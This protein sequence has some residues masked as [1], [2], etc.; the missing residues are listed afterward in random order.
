MSITANQAPL[1]V[2]L[3][4]FMATAT[5]PDAVHLAWATA[6]ERNSA[7][8][9]VERSTDGQAFTSLVILKA[10]GTS[11]SPIAYEWV[12]AKLPANHKTLYYRLR[13]T[14]LDATT[15]YSPVRTVTQTAARATSQLQAY[16]NPAHDK[17]S[18]K[19]SGL[20]LIVPVTEYQVFDSQ[21]RLVRT[22]AVSD[23]ATEVLLP[24]TGLPAGMYL[25]RYGSLIQYLAVE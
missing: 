13:Q 25:L 7:S 19:V 20:A 18:V 16:P 2:V 5:G 22:Q 9:A 11:S 10:A 12:D 4:K 15:T 14:D 21:G 3:V 6:S 1:P 23:A 8:F 24:L 17:V